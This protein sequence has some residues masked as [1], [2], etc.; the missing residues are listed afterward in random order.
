MTTT[1]MG[2]DVTMVDL[3]GGP[4]RPPFLSLSDV[5]LR[6]NVDGRREQQ[7]GG[8]CHRGGGQSHEII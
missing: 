7:G 5:V 3:D 4:S 1:M 6:I 2:D 8:R